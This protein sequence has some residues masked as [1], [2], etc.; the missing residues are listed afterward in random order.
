MFLHIGF[1][2]TI[3]A[4]TNSFP[5]DSC[6]DSD[7]P[8][9]T[10]AYGNCT[11]ARFNS[12]QNSCMG[13]LSIKAS[14]TDD[15]TPDELISFEYKIDLY[16]DGSGTHN[17][18]DFRVGPLSPKQLNDGLD[19]S[20]HDNS[21]AVN[22]KNSL[23]ASGTYPIGI[24]KICWYAEDTC[25]N[26][27]ALCQLFEVEDCEA[28]VVVCVGGVQTF[29]MS[30]NG[31]ITLYAKDFNRGSFD[32]CTHSNKL[33][34]YFNGNYKDSSIVVCCDDYVVAGTYPE[35]SL[36]L[37]LWVEDEMGNS[38]FCTVSV[39]VE[40]Y[41]QACPID[42]SS[43]IVYGNLICLRNG[44][45]NVSIP[46]IKMSSYLNGVVLRS[47]VPKS[48]YQ[49]YFNYKPGPYSLNAIKED[50]ILN[51]VSTLDIIYLEKHLHK[52]EKFSNEFQLLSADVNRDNEI[53]Y[54][55]IL[56]I[57]NLVLVDNIKFQNTLPW[58]ILAISKDS[59]P[60][61][62]PVENIEFEFD[63]NRKIRMDFR[64]I[65]MG[66]VNDYASPSNYVPLIKTNDSLV[67]NFVNQLLRKGELVEIDFY[68]NVFKS[69][70]GFQ[71][72]F[73]FNSQKLSYKN[74]NSFAIALD[75]QNLGTNL[76]K[77]GF[78]SISWN[79]I[80]PRTYSSN[81]ALF[82]LEFEA[83]EDG[84]LCDALSFTSDLTPAEAYTDSVLIKNIKL[85]SCDVVIKNE[86]TVADQI[87]MYPNPAEEILHFDFPKEVS[88]PLQIDI[89]SRDGR[90]IKKL[91]LSSRTD[92]YE[93]RL[94]PF[95]SG[96]Y[97][98]KLS[99]KKY[100]TLKNFIKI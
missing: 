36:N 37:Q 22:S 10:I 17:N 38:D 58:K 51:N 63:K 96:M 24:H 79:D 55:D 14:A 87:K 6:N 59:I 28:P 40:D 86:E 47:Q 53:G 33:Y 65:K 98:V 83:L 19:P 68:S 21:F 20:F 12:A 45:E 95:L 15:Q 8:V 23:D 31:C 56:E 11:P 35:L 2:C 34:Y 57:R 80:Y 48:S 13:Y 5:V 41:Q 27:A 52:L 44:N 7:K 69:I 84:D 92:H 16:N 30:W 50:D 64:I 91:S 43:N 76:L 25:G 75:K 9:I 93:L 94:N 1:C 73:K 66:D 97:F 32:N 89:Y 26:Q 39:L 85:E 54:L 71:G 78:L 42:F 49:F 90:E 88:F 4:N 67:F 29:E 99:E 70:V 3:T 82:S 100:V 77:S 60:L 81:N 18:F 61:N 62:K 72:T 74:F 46:N